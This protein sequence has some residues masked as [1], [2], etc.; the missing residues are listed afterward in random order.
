MAFI[1]QLSSWARSMQPSPQLLLLQAALQMRRSRAGRHTQAPRALTLSCS[2][3]HRGLDWRALGPSS[4]QRS[5][6]ELRRHQDRAWVDLQTMMQDMGPLKVPPGGLWDLDHQV[7][8]LKRIPGAHLLS[9]LPVLPE[10]PLGLDLTCGLTS[11]R[12]GNGI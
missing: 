1:R 7:P 9:S 11:A 5:C 8:I 2:S 10:Q 3:T 6:Q 4:R 12:E